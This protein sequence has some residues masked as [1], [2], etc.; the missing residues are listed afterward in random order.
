MRH[1]IRLKHYAYSTEESCV[2]WVKR[3]ML[4]HDKRHPREMAEAEIEAFLTH[5]AVERHGR[6]RR[7]C[8]GWGWS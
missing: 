4:F 2:H 5:L 3:Y 7:S 6:A 1:A 8:Q